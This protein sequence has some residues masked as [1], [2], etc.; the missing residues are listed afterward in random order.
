MSF[1][2]KLLPLCILGAAIPAM[3]AMGR[4]P[5]DKPNVVIV[6]LDDSGYGDFEF[7]GNKNVKTPHLNKMK[8]EGLFMSH[9]Y[10]GSPACTASRYALMTGKSPARSGLKRW[11]LSPQNAEYI[12]PEEQTVPETMKQAGYVTGMIGK[13]HLGVTNKANGMDTKSL[14]CAHGFDTYIG[15]PYSND[16]TPT[17]LIQQPGDS[18]AYPSA[19]VLENPVEQDKLTQY[20]FNLACDF[21]KKNKN[22]PFFLY[23]ATS[24]PHYPLH[25]G[26]DFRGKSSSGRIYDDVIEEIDHC[27]GQLLGTIDKAGIGR[28]TLVI[29]S[30]DNGPWLIKGDQGGT[31]LPFRDGKGSNFEGG[32]R[33]PGIFRWTGVI[34]PG[35]TNDSIASVLDIHPTLCTLTKQEF[36]PHGHADGH[37]IAHIL[38]PKFGG[39]TIEDDDYVLIQTGKGTNKAM[40]VHWKNWKLHI[41][42]FSQLWGQKKITDHNSPPVKATM[43]KPLLYDLSTDIAETTNVADKHPEIVE[44]MKKKIKEFNASL[45]D[46]AP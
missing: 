46:E 37:S 11:V 27:M 28:N 17:P 23:L 43:D 15:I 9:F 30:S 12:K 10:S 8:D 39:K 6:Y 42:T 21:V 41:D 2:Q 40:A 1:L 18:K 4:A 33:V 22:R 31:A 32:V 16:M 20:Y 13:W 25:P 44:F 36:K 38:N 7:T 35:Q 24:M 14:P 3:P 26:K 34:S 19:K 29:F 5:L 45:K